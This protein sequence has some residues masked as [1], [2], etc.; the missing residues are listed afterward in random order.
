MKTVASREC[1]AS[2]QIIFFFFSF[3]SFG[4][5]VAEKKIKAINSHAG[6]CFQIAQTWRKLTVRL[7]PQNGHPTFLE[8]ALMTFDCA[9]VS[10][11]WN[12]KKLYL[13][14]MSEKRG[15]ERANGRFSYN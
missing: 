1:H 5:V 7:S 3:L 11:T 12:W 10:G 8:F 6:R 14:K 2:W 13:P 9:P 15:A 4:L